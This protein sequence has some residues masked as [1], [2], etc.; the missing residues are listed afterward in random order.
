[1]L[2]QTRGSFSPRRRA[3]PACR[4]GASGSSEL[5][6]ANTRTK[7]AVDVRWLALRGGSRRS[8]SRHRRRSAAA[9]G[10]RKLSAGSARLP[11]PGAPRSAI[12]GTFVTTARIA[13]LPAPGAQ[14]S[15]STGTFVNT[16]S[17]RLTCG[18]LV[19]RVPPRERERGRERESEQASERASGGASKRASERARPSSTG[20]VV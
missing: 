17:W 15:A 19:A 12:T 6:S 10:I 8:S 9:M 11:A 2:I 1:M 4:G 14:R 7:P 18:D 5:C 13:R 20:E 16:A 3:R